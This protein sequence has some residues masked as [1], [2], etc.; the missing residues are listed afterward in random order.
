MAKSITVKTTAYG[1]PWDSMEGS[2]TTS[3]GVKLKAGQQKLVVAVD[4]T[5]I[6]YGTKLKI[7]GNPLGN[8]NLVFTAADTGGAFQGGTNKLD[9]F[10]AGKGSEANHDR[11][12]NWGVKNLKAYIVGRGSPTSVGTLAGQTGAAKPAGKTVTTTTTKIPGTSTTTTDDSA[13]RA[14]ILGFI[15][16]N[17]SNSLAAALNVKANPVTSSTVT[18]PGKTLTSTKTTGTSKT[19]GDALAKVVKR[20]NVVNDKHL[21]YL[22]GGGHG[23]KV[24]NVHKATPVDCSGAVS[25]ALHINPRVS[26]DLANWGKPGAGKN[27]TIYANGT[28]TFLEI[29]GHFWGTSSSNPGGGAGWI[30]KSNFDQAY[31]STFTKRHPAGM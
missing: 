7:P 16:S 17:P 21:P 18:T 23:A 20:A 10:I 8:D 2:G 3:T 22:W 29:N 12:N 30:P 4:P 11:L 1:P 19:A 26:G 25:E 5:V 15:Q 27:V 24:N 13:H 31:L 28:H 14:A 6:P 9:F